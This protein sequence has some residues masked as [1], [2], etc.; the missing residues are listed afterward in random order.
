MPEALI[1]EILR[2]SE[3]V[4]ERNDKLIFQSRIYLLRGKRFLF[5]IYVTKRKPH[6]VITVY[7]TS[8]IRRYYDSEIR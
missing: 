4:L 7:K 3:Q 6:K 2:S 5:R 8:K 1:D